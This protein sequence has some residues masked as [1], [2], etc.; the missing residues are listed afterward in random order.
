MRVRYKQ[1]DNGREGEWR[2]DGA[3]V[4]IGRE[5]GCDYV[6]SGDGDDVV[7]SRHLQLERR[8]D[9]V[10]VVDLSSTNGTYVNGD[11]V[12]D[13]RT[14][15]TGDAL[16]LG[17]GGPTFEVLQIERARPEKP[18]EATPKAGF[19]YSGSP[20]V[21]ASAPAVAPPAPPMNPLDDDGQSVL[22]APSQ[23][24]V[25][26]TVGAATREIVLHV[27]RRQSLSW[28]ILAGVLS[29]LGLLVVAVFLAIPTATG[30]GG[31][32]AYD[33][34][35][36]CSLWVVQ[37][38]S[39]GSGVIVRHRGE[40]YGLT[41]W[42]VTDPASEVI[43]FAPEYRDGRLL[44]DV[45]SVIRTRNGIRAEVIATSSEK[46]VSIL[47]LEQIPDGCEPL[48]LARASPRSGEAI[49]T[50]GNPGVAGGDLWIYSDGK[51]RSVSEKTIPSA[52]ADGELVNVF[53]GTAVS[54]QYP[55]NPGDSGGPMMN[56]R[57]ELVGLNMS[58]KRQA[59]LF[60]SG[61]DVSE[62]R[63]M[64]DSVAHR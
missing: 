31:D 20:A 28:R 3:P 18:R 17:A 13:A 19:A 58:I 36:K 24:V 54:A 61:V 15:V 64:L 59:N 60:S 7:S 50:I 46:D 14:L 10:A 52:G 38:G 6:A 44:K 45:E 49:F 37:E 23:S 21:A 56:G 9:R 4:V 2:L 42:H 48:P 29:G 43:V 32:V 40:H 33:R 53:R 8:G 1:L 35:L 27:M 57:F 11:R 22:I 39:T 62:V 16:R 55:I 51:V 34:L 47:R 63:A 12:D 5:A 30:V 26:D 25:G 41:N